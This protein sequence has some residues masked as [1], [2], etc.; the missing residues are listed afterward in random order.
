M[1]GPGAE[2]GGILQSSSCKLDLKEPYYRMSQPQAYSMVQDQQQQQLLQSQVLVSRLTCYLI[3]FAVLIMQ[4]DGFF[5]LLPG[6]QYLE[7]YALITA[8]HVWKKKSIFFQKRKI[9]LHFQ[10]IWTNQP[11]AGIGCCLYLFIHIWNGTRKWESLLIPMV[12][13]KLV[14]NG[15]LTNGSNTRSGIRSSILKD[16]DFPRKCKQSHFDS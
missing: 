2:Q 11:G 3:D 4:M 14:K 1:W 5:G 10:E 7:V 9:C 12:C 13:L 16:W 6:V 8:C 15:F